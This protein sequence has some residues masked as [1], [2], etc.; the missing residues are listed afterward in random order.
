MCRFYRFGGI[1]ESIT[2]VIPTGGG[3]SIPTAPTKTSLILLS[4]QI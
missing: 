3:S 2:Y 4:F 1:E